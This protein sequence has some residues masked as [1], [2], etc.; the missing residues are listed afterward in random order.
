[1]VTI[2]KRRAWNRVNAVIPD[3]KMQSTNHLV[4]SDSEK[5]PDIPHFDKQGYAIC[6]VTEAY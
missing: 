5:I 2:S 4:I 1:M 3:I 6:L